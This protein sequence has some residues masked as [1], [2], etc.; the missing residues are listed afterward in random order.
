[1]T[2]KVA[3]VVVVVSILA[4]LAACLWWYVILPAREKQA[5]VDRYGQKAYDLFCAA[6]ESP[7]VTLGTYEQDGNLGNG[8]EPIEWI[9]L[10]KEGMSLLLISRYALDFQSYHYAYTIT[11]WEQCSLRQ[12]L[13]QDFVKA[14]FSAAER[15]ML[16]TVTVKARK[17]DVYETDAGKDTQDT[18]FL[19]DAFEANEWLADGACKAT[20]YAAQE[21][22]SVGEDGTCWWWLRSP[23]MYQNIAAGVSRDGTVGSSGRIVSE[24]CAV[25][26]ALWV[27][28]AYLEKHQTFQKG[29]IENGKTDLVSR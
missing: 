7:F 1:M 10:K 17:N 13:N 24:V 11:T 18:V 16:S 2:K 29:E 21:R 28:L 23:G 27:D 14:A 22:Y 8:K 26:P 3:L 25:R 15:E 12:W 19:L 6:K 9:V 4:I 5:F 20:A